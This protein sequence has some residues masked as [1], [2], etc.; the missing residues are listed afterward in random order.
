M[1]EDKIAARI[2]G[3]TQ[4]D[5]R[6]DTA[7][8]IFDYLELVQRCCGDVELAAR[9]TKR[10]QHRSESDISELEDA[11]GQNQADTIVVLAH[12]L[13]GTAGNLAAHRLRECAEQLEATGRRGDLSEAAKLVSELRIE[14]GR[15]N[16]AVSATFA[17]MIA[18]A[19]A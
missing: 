10:F 18:K 19:R 13:K 2:D 16:D 14:T 11:V 1:P 17:E 3:G 9:V 4:T 7:S 6:F 8:P 5:T 12:R 15:F